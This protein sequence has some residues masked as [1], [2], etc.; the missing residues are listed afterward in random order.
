[1][2]EDQWVWVIVVRDPD[3]K[4]QFLGQ[5]DAEQDLSFIPAFLSKE[6]ATEG[7]PYFI[8][9][10]DNAYEVQAILF[11]DLSDRAAASG[12]SLFILNGKGEILKQI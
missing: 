5:Y 1:M 10:K 9:E 6:E 12:F 8:K 11:E 2:K 7:L 3:G 4:E